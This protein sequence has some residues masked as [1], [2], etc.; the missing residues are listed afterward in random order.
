MTSSLQGA[1]R[2]LDAEIAERVFGWK[3]YRVA[4]YPPMS[5][6]AEDRCWHRPG[7]DA[8][9]SLPLFSTGVA[10]AWMVVE[11]M[12]ELGWYGEV[13]LCDDGSSASFNPV[14]PGHYVKRSVDPREGNA[15]L[16]VCLCALAALSAKEA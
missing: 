6:G 10:A 15:A 5:Q 8:P 1:G 11:R 2:E 3:K 13:R 12:L 16:A 9:C 4:Q 14:G 7:I